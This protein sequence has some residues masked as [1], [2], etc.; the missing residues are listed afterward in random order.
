MWIF[1]QEPAEFDVFEVF[2]DRFFLPVCQVISRRTTN[3]DVFERIV[4][5]IFAEA[6]SRFQADGGTSPSKFIEAIAAG[7]SEEALK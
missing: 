5:H 6:W 7:V 1:D 4:T 2:L 3:E